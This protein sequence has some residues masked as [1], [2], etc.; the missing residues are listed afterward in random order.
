MS[1]LAH[2]C[3][4]PETAAALDTAFR[5]DTAVGVPAPCF[6]DA[7][8]APMLR[9]GEI[10][11]WR[12]DLSSLDSSQTGCMSPGELGRA[13]KFRFDR[14]RNRFIASRGIVRA[15]LGRYTA[16][17][18]WEIELVA[19]PYGKP[20]IVGEGAH[21][22]F[23]LSHSADTLLVALTRDCE[24]GVDVEATRENLPFEMLA[25]HYLDPGEIWQLRI[26]PPHRQAQLFYNFWTV[27]EARLKARGR[28]LAADSLHLDETDYF[29]SIFSPAPGYA[30]AVAID[31]STCSDSAR[32]RSEF[33]IQH[34][35]WQN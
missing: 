30:A 33:V 34:Y 29:T 10:H 22:R 4:S 2:P 3:D 21:V 15:I 27:L 18:P 31:L 20:S 25:K 28:G 7:P 9:E 17:E 26:A 35:Q 6:E 16:R 13:R 12:G 24:V 23:N 19:G 1:I 32:R 8:D 14:D 11:L 5:G